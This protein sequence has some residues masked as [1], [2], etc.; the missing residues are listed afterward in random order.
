VE[1]GGLVLLFQFWIETWF[2]SKRVVGLVFWAFAIYLEQ[3]GFVS[4]V[5]VPVR[6][7]SRLMCLRFGGKFLKV[8]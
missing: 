6:D 5:K 2:V 4:Q 1:R 3:E 7:P 8:R